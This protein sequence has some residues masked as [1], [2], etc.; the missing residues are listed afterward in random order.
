MSALFCVGF[1]IAFVMS[2]APP[3]APPDDAS[4]GVGLQLSAGL[5]VQAGAWG[6]GR[7]TGFRENA[8]PST[9][10]RAGLRSERFELGLVWE[11]AWLPLRVAQSHLLADA[12]W[13][14]SLSPVF[15]LAL[16]M[17]G[18]V[19]VLR[20]GFRL[21]G[22]GWP[23]TPLACA[24]G[25]LELLLRTGGWLTIGLPLGMTADLTRRRVVAPGG[26]VLGGFLEVAPEPYT[27]GGWTVSARLR[28]H[29]DVT[30]LL[31]R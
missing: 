21:A 29:A 9:Q 31:S 11:E 23:T 18:G 17:K 5:G 22:G 2:A 8:L 30:R 7:E 28:V 13:R 6:E 4:P 1:A 15:S 12:G 3:L 16:R 25:E 14:L 26:E 27:L 19:H 20:D 10:V 24:G